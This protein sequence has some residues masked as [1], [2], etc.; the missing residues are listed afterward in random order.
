MNIDH[1]SRDGPAQKGRPRRA[2]FVLDLTRKSNG[3]DAAAPWARPR[4]VPRRM[5]ASAEQKSMT[6]T[7]K[8]EPLLQ[9][10]AEVLDRLAPPPPLDNDLDLADAFVWH[11]ERGWLE[12]VP[13]VNR[14]DLELLQGIDRVRDILLDNT[15]RFAAGLPANNVLLW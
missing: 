3:G 7:R 5:M 1:S 10:V 14:V 4:R 2:A 6:D 15:R 13:A 9:R 12:P 11:A 8:L